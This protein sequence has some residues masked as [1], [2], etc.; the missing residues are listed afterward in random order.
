[1]IKNYITFDITTSHF[2]SRTS[3]IAEVVHD[4]ELSE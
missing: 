4:C 2:K 1:M 3:E